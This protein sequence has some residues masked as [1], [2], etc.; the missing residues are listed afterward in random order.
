MGL[1]VVFI[2]FR[3]RPFEHAERS[4]AIMGQVMGLEARAAELIAFRRA[5][6]EKVTA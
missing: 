4:I 1:P 5:E 2:D 6:M 3:E